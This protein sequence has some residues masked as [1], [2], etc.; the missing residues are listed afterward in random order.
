MLSKIHH[1]L[2]YSEKLQNRTV[3]TETAVLR[4]KVAT[5][6]W[7]N[8]VEL[9]AHTKTWVDFLSKLPCLLVFRTLKQT[10]SVSASPEKLWLLHMK[11]KTDYLKTSTFSFALIKNNGK[12]SKALWLSH[13]SHLQPENAVSSNKTMHV[14]SSTK[15]EDRWESMPQ[16]DFD[17]QWLISEHLHQMLPA[18]QVLSLVKTV[19]TWDQQVV[20]HVLRVHGMYP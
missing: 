8:S 18:K 15:E 4:P 13:H 9:R 10:K 3:S 11:S 17:S 16:K 7:A 20:A 5:C 2:Q 19:Q 14:T 6:G 12:I 1:T